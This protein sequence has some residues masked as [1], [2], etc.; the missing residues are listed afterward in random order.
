MGRLVCQEVLKS[1]HSSGK[2]TWTNETTMNLYEIY[3]SIPPHLWNMVVGVLRPGHVQ[4]P[5]VPFGF[6]DITADGIS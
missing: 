5:K 1:N 3:Q 6:I 2:K 4:L